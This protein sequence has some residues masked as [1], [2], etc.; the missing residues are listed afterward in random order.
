MAGETIPN[1]YLT[2][3]GMTERRSKKAPRLN[4]SRH[5]LFVHVPSG[6]IARGGKMPSSSIFFV[7]F[8]MFASVYS[9]YTLGPPRGTKTVPKYLA[10]APRPGIF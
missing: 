8:K 6:K 7:R 4:G 3:T 10:I 5:V 9:N 1:L 2:V